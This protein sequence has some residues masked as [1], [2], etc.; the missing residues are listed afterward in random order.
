MPVGVLS[1][2]LLPECD[3]SLGRFALFAAF[4]FKDNCIFKTGRIGKKERKA[5]L[6]C[7]LIDK[8]KDPA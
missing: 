5:I 1:D 8:D 6:P 4:R 7:V 3:Q 2:Q